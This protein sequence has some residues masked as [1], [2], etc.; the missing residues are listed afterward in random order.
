MAGLRRYWPLLVAAF[1]CSARGF[2]A[3]PSVPGAVPAET[4]HGTI[5]AKDK[6]AITIL[7]HDAGKTRRITLTADND[8]EKVLRD[9]HLAKL[10]VAVHG[11]FTGK[12][13]FELDPFFDKPIHAMK[14]G[15][16]LLV[17]YWCGNCGIRYYLP[18]KCICCGGDTNLDLHEE[19]TVAAK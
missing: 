10:D 7:T 13:K 5:E 17:T 16:E 9:R 11:H 8:G 12:T 1:V 19:E 2:A 15:K 3:A 6:G 18:G 14:D 4:L